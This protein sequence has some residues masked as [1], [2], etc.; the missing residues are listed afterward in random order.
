MTNTFVTS[1]SHFGHANIM[2]YTQEDLGFAPRPFIR[3]KDTYVD[4]TCKTRWRSNHIAKERAEEMDEALIKGWNDTVGPNDEVFHLGDFVF[5]DAP[6]AI[7]LIS[8][9]NGKIN[10]I[11]GNHDKG[12]KKAKPIINSTPLQHR[13]NFLGDYHVLKREENK[14]VLFHYPILVWDRM[15]YGAY[16]LC[17]HSHGSCVAS[18]PNT[19]TS[20]LLDVGVD[21]HGLR[22]W[23]LEEI[24]GHLKNN[25]YI[26]PDH[27][28]T[29]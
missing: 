10:F 28:K 20:R 17:G 18:N 26:A 8:R 15:H 11:W 12:I 24:V 14:F 16:G 7:R 4:D 27:H 25:K 1:D 5:G 9:L 19:T 13:V 29:R 22:P 2:I 6:D 3:D 23:A 21:T